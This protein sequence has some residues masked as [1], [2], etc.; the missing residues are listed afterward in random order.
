MV[1]KVR[2][3]IFHIGLI[4]KVDP[5]KLFLVMVPTSLADIT[6]TLRG[7]FRGGLVY[8]VS[9]QRLPPCC[10]AEIFRIILLQSN[11]LRVKY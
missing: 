8:V 1:I 2:R 4:P 11:K 7:C 5:L 6:R 3:Q 9:F 10:Q